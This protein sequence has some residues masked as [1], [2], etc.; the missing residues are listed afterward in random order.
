M[1]ESG[2]KLQ[3]F[4]EK[5]GRLFVHALNFL[6]STVPFR[7]VLNDVSRIGMAYIEAMQLREASGLVP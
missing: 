4:I 1:C 7:I 5:Q 2:A 3:L 6:Y